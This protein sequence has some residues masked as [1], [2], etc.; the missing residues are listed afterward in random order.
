ME[1]FPDYKIK[2]VRKSWKS[3]N[4]ACEPVDLSGRQYNKL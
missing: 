4:S 3:A 1:K 2:L